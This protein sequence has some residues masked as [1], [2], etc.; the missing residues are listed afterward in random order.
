MQHHRRPW[1]TRRAR[2]AATLSASALALALGGSTA[3]AQDSLG[4]PF[5]NKVPTTL[6]AKVIF[7]HHTGGLSTGGWRIQTATD[8][9]YFVFACS[10][11]FQD[12]APRFLS[13]VGITLAAG[14]GDLDIDLYLPNGTFVGGS[15]GTGTKEEVVLSANL[16]SVFLKV[17]GFNGATG[18]YTT[19]FDCR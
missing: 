1:H 9:D 11:D 13:R 6:P 18:G 8:V 4:E 14:A 7:Q 5:N 17:R 3:L 19:S 10:Q 15:W 2:A 16:T 12:E